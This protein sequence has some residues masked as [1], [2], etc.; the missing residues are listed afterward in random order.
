MD[1]G[2]ASR[3]SAGVDDD[4][5]SLLSTTDAELLKRAWRNEKSAPEI[6]QY[7]TALVQRSREQTQLM[8]ETVEDFFKNGVDPLTAS[9]YQ[10][11]R[12]RTLFLLISYLRTR[13]KGMSLKRDLFARHRI[14]SLSIKNYAFHIQKITDLW[15]RL[16]KQEQKFVERCIDD[17]EQHLDQ[18]VLSKL[19]HGFKSH[20]KQSSLSLG[21]DMVPEPQLHQYVICRSKRLLGSFQL[22]DSGEEPVNI[23]ANDLYV[24]PYK[25]IKPLVESGQIDLV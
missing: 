16:S 4:Y 8:E 9:L 15:N 21:D 13:L 18:S 19:P 3:Y 1:S 5:E 10:M 17:M 7:E 24:L 23:E 25:S 22:D 11:D 14:S 20:L 6:L 2:D 12:D